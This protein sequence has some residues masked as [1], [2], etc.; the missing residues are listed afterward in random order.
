[1]D[2]EAFERDGE[3]EEEGVEPWGV[4]AFSEVLAGRHDHE[5]LRRRA[6][7]DLLD[8]RGAGTLA[9]A[10]LEDKWRDAPGAEAVG[11]KMAVL[12]PL[13]ENEAAP[14]LVE[15]FGDVAAD[16]PGA[17]FV[18]DEE[19]EHFLDRCLA[20]RW[21][22]EFGLADSEIAARGSSSRC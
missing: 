5:L 15:S 16:E 17:G 11:E 1:M 8:D 20:C 21:D 4:E 19:P 9:K 18:V 14:A 7:L 3:G 10:P 13:A 2:N 6:G 22:R 12:R